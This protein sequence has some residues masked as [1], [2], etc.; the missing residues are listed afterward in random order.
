[1]FQKVDQ[2]TQQIA[3]GKHQ[4][5]IMILVGRYLGWPR[6]QKIDKNIYTAYGYGHQIGTIIL[7][8]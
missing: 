3:D 5:E 4:L 1:M 6:F 7:M 8:H 2:R